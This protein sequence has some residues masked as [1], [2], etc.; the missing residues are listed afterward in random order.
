MSIVD[1]RGIHPFIIYHS[2]G[3]NPNTKPIKKINRKFFDVTVKAVQQ[4]DNKLIAV[5]FIQEVDY[6]DWVSNVVIVP[7]L[8][9]K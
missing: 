7:K 8:E 6:L 5:G 1:I 2:L 4:E 3:V 9:N